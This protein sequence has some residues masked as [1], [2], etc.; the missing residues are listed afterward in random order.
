MGLALKNS[1]QPSIL[2]WDPNGM[3]TKR[4]CPNW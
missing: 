2:M 4:W 3:F 1:R